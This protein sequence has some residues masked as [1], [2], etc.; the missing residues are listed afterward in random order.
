[1]VLGELTDGIQTGYELGG[2]C[3][4]T[5]KDKRFFSLDSVQIGS[6]AHSYCCSVYAGTCSTLLKA[7]GA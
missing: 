4:I 6:G 5:D 3:L 1:M 2:M 7:A